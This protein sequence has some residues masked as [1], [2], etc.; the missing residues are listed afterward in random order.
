MAVRPI[1]EPTW[2]ER[3]AL[4]MSE[5]PRSGS[6]V[7]RQRWRRFPSGGR[8]NFGSQASAGAAIVELRTL[9]L[10]EMDP[11]SLAKLTP[12]Q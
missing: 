4:G 11:T 12:E 6:D 2:D 1:M 10:S 3:P 7:G 9:C 5:S 8:T